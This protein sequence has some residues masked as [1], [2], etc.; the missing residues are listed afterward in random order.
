M[1]E[2]SNLFVGICGMVLSLDAAT[3]QEAWRTRLKGGDFVN[4]CLMDSG[5]Y[6]STKGE[7]FALDGATGAIL[8][9]NKLTGLGTG[10]VTIGGA[11][12]VPPAMAKRRKQQND[13]GGAAA[14]A[15]SG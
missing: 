9:H 11:G 5:L 4:V 8:W 3:G 10:F 15:A 7:L 12:Q 13:A 14:A 6:A 1:N 2:Q